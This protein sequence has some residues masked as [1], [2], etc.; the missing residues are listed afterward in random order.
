MQGEQIPLW[1][2]IVAVADAYDA[3]TNDRPYRP[4]LSHEQAIEILRTERERQFD[5]MIV[6][7]F[8]EPAMFSMGSPDPIN[9]A[10]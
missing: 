9:A 8:L 1:G 4:A 10:P 6:D 3:M 7:A 5:P 2:R